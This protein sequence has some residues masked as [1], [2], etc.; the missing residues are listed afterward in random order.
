[1]VILTKDIDIKFEE[2]FCGQN[3]RSRQHQRCSGNVPTQ[4][5][6]AG[7]RDDDEK[8]KVNVSIE[9]WMKADFSAQ[10]DF[11]LAR[12]IGAAVKARTAIGASIGVALH[13]AVFVA[14]RF[15]LAAVV[16]A[17]AF[18]FGRAR[19]GRWPAA[20]VSLPWAAAA[21]RAGR[22]RRVRRRRRYTGRSGV[23]GLVMALLFPNGGTRCCLY[24]VQNRRAHR[25]SFAGRAFCAATAAC[26]CASNCAISGCALAVISGASGEGG[27]RG[28]GDARRQAPTG[29]AAPGRTH[30]RPPSRMRHPRRQKHDIGDI[31]ARQAP[32]RS[33]GKG[34]ARSAE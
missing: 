10:D 17:A 1:M 28:L 30:A 22:R 32:D 2:R 19:R 26:I 24:I 31:A 7:Q 29:V 5:K 6:D 13:I 21:A 15:A 20:A 25:Q 23:A 4:Q 9:R 8:E 27:A 18:L 34:A 11:A 16:A 12:Q 33:G 3:Y 14:R